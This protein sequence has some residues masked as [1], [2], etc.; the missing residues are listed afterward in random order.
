MPLLFKTPPERVH[1][2]TLTAAHAKFTFCKRHVD[3]EILQKGRKAGYPERRFNE[4]VI[5]KWI[6]KLLSELQ[7]FEKSAEFVTAIRSQTNKTATA[8]SMYSRVITNIS[9]SAKITLPLISKQNTRKQWKHRSPWS[10]KHPWSPQVSSP[11]TKFQWYST[12]VH[13]LEPNVSSLKNL[14]SVGDGDLEFFSSFLVFF[15]SYLF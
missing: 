10:Q 6:R 5:A 14:G 3:M 11:T 4:R 15:S 9:V 12:A 13:L 8:K 1:R 7:K 2:D